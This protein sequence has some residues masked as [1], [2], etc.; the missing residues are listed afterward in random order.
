MKARKLYWIWIVSISATLAIIGLQGYWLYNQHKYNI[1]KNTDETEKHILSVWDNYKILQKKRLRMQKDDLQSYSTNL[2]QNNIYISNTNEDGSMTNWDITLITNKKLTISSTQK[3]KTLKT[4]S[5]EELKDL[6]KNIKETLG[7]LK[8]DLLDS[9]SIRS[10][11]IKDSLAK[12]NPQ[13]I[14]S[15]I[16]RPWVTS[17]DTTGKQTTKRLRFSTKENQSVIYDAVDLYLSYANNPFR[18]TELD[19]LMASENLGVNFSTDTFTL[20]RDSVLWNPQT[21]KNTQLHNPSLTVSIPYNLLDKKVYKI[22][23]IIPPNAIITQMFWQIII[24]AL[25]LILLIFALGIQIKTISQQMK[26]NRLRKNFVNTTIHELK[27]PIQTLK[28]MVS[29]LQNKSADTSYDST[30][31]QEVRQETDNLTSYLQ[32]LKEVN[33]GESIADSIHVSRFNFTELVQQTIASVKKNTSKNVHFE[34]HFPEKEVMITADRITLVNVITNLLEN[35][36][37]Y[38]G[39]TVDIIFKA[40][41]KENKL[42]FSIT[43]NGFGIDSSEQSHIIEPF[44]RSKNE[45]VKALPGMGLGLSYVKMITEAHN[46]SLRIESQLNKGTTVTIEIPQI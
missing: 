4:I 1:Q 2:N 46:G 40:E 16:N 42:R 37:K 20:S 15:L 13:Q 14:D 26:V 24:T 33:D 35:A 29:Y 32:K 38:S 6:S 3:E 25:L 36:I 17:L 28:S 9:V 30:I 23:C 34:L 31:L 8:P 7:R 43:D 12:A 21:E 19:S 45:K 18:K 27:R 44:F 10:G 11:S 22:T 41:K 5:K 39:E